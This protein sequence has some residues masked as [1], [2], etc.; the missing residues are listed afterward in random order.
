MKSYMSFVVFGLAVL[1]F[2]AQAMAQGGG[3]GR[4]GMG[5]GGGMGRLMILTRGGEELNKELSL[6]DDQTEKLGDLAEE[7]RGM[8]GGGGGGRPDPEDIADME[9]EAMAILDEKQNDRLTGIFAQVSGAAALSD[10]VIAKKLGLTDDDKKKIADAI[11]ESQSSM[12][13]KMQELRDSGDDRDA[14]M[15]KMQ[16]LRKEST[17]SVL[18]VLSTEQKEKFAKLQGEKFEMA[19]GMF[20]G[21]GGPGGGRG[22]AGGGAG[23]AGG[24]RGGAGGGGRGGQGGQ[25]GD[26]P[27]STG[28]DGF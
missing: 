9:K 17:D 26:A 19:G 14:M 22:G 28:G 24:G 6:T 13:E 27:K 3:G 1:G 18:A 4:G 7:M 8:F 2:S 25:G 12:R 15:E 23:G 16:E 20:G 21:R 11:E 5:R 10:A